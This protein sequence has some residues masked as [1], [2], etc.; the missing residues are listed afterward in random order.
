MKASLLYP[1]QCYLGEGPVWHATRKSCFW[2]DIERGN[3]YE[4]GWLQKA[5]KKWSVPYKVTVV[6]PGKNNKLILGLNNGIARFD[7]ETENL[8][9]LADVE[10]GLHNNRCNDGACDSNGRLWI[11]T[12]DMGFSKS[13]GA[14]YCID[15]RYNVQ[16]KVPDTTIANGLAWS[17]DNKKLYFIDSGGQTVQAFQF[18]E[19][20]G[21]I[22][23]EKNVIEIPKDLGTPDGMAIDTEGMLW[24]AQWGG[25]GVYRWNPFTGT[26]IDKIDVPAPNV[27]SCAFAGEELDHLIITTAQQDLSAADLERYPQSG[28]VF[29][30]RTDVKGAAAHTCAF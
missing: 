3:L 13:C 26:L 30:V 8:E 11:G 25:F 27:S 24:I 2:V 12:M 18:D 4:Y 14:L 23:F 22:A 19:E 17:Q 1:S 6:Q 16:K 10:T 28:D 5:V 9:W 29:Y 7:P 21:A 15:E 20:K